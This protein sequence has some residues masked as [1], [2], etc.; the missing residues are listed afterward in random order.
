M[1]FIVT[2]IFVVTLIVLVNV[3][4]NSN[5]A[6]QEVRR[7]FSVHLTPFLWAICAHLFSKIIGESEEIP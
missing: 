7:S 4:S 6:K 2:A 5:G 1:F 3:L